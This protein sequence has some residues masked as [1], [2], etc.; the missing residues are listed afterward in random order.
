MST[1]CYM[2]IVQHRTYLVISVSDDC[3]FAENIFHQQ[4][5]WLINLI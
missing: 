5:L 2:A 1:K 3:E 4:D